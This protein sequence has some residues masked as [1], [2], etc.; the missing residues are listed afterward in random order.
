MAGDSSRCIEAL[1]L[2]LYGAH[3]ALEQFISRWPLPH[4]TGSPGRRVLSASPTSIRPSDLSRLLGD[5]VLQAPL[6]PDG[7]PLFP[8]SPS[9]ACWRYEPR[10]HSTALANSHLGILPSLLRDKV[11][12]FHHDRY[13]GYL[14][15]HFRSGLLPPCLRFAATV[16]GH[17]ARLGT[18]L[19]ARL[20][21]GHHLR[22]LNYMRFPRRNPHRSRRAQ[23]TH[24]APTLGD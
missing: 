14:S 1:Y 8:C 9:I 15:V 23:L 5:P 21:R 6:D 17:H 22:R 13:R 10:K 7:S 20:C 16:T 18:R 2:P 19:L 24:R 3:V 4:V 11:G 12:C